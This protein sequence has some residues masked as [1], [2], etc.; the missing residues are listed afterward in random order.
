MATNAEVLADSTA[1]A[2]AAAA[3]IGGTYNMNAGGFVPGANAAK[4]GAG[5]APDNEF[6]KALQDRLLGK[7]GVASSASSGLDTAIQ[8]N[9]DMLKGAAAKSEAGINAKYTAD[10][11][12]V[13]DK[14]ALDRVSAQEGM[15]TAGQASQLAIL[16]MLDDRTAKS[17]RDLELQK[18]QA[19][20]TGAF[21]TAS[22][23]ADLQMQQVQF[24]ADQ[25]QKV[26][27]NLISAANLFI[28]QQSE[29]RLAQSAAD[30][31]EA[32]KATIA[33]KYGIE[34]KPGQNLA[35][36]VK[37]AMPNASKEEKLSLQKMQAEINSLN[38]KSTPAGAVVSASLANAS[39]VINGMSHF[40]SVGR[41]STLAASQY[42]DPEVYLKLRDDFS[43]ANGGK[44]GTFD[45][46]FAPRLSP[47]DRA[48]LGVGTASGVKAEDQTQ[49]IIDALT[50]GN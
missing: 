9:I 11:N 43:H 4:S 42:I 27:G 44:V 21:D 15:N 34:L 30:S 26:F 35:D 38:K 37:A 40:D 22:K 31:L 46:Q 14:A 5:G 36:V 17:I 33:L 25:E 39:A 7:T 45:A 8:G 12:A 1:A 6:M 19:L 16:G 28:S 3:S 49:A 50:S 24:K 23:I 18:T 13:R 29:K 41:K 10:E 48:R 47:S 2:N 20:A 32:S